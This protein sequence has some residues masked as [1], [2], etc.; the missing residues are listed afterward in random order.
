MHVGYHVIS[1]SKIVFLGGADS[2]YTD[3]LTVRDGS[4]VVAGVKGFVV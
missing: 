3:E 1:V 4:F 2:T